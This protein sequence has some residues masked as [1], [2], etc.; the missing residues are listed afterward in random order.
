MYPIDL[1]RLRED[2]M[3]FKVIIAG[4]REFT[5]YSF[6]EQK[7]DL[8]LSEKSQS[9][10][11]V[12]VEGGARG[13]DRLGRNYAHSRGYEVVTFPANWDKYGKG[14][15]FIRN[16]E[17]ANYADALIAFWDGQSPGTKHMINEAKEKGLAVRIQ[18]YD[19]N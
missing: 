9:H 1:E 8:L 19:K 6:L 18:R 12:I 13:A 2:M 14:A 17:M 10:R 15:G 11:I 16:R 7:V 5:D 4:G 3:T